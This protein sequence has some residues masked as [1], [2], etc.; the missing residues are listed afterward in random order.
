[1]E[2]VTADTARAVVDAVVAQASQM[3]VTSNVAVVDAGGNLKAFHRMDG[4]MLGS[5]D[6]AIK[7]A[8]TAR[9]F[10]MNT[11][12]LG[13]LTAPGGALAGIELT[14]DGLI[15]FGG[16]TPLRTTDGT[17]MGAV[18]VS[19]STV[20]DDTFLAATGAKAAS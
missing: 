18:G 1:M 4:A 8:R 6:V 3:G 13:P 12:E 10:D 15:T 14:N 11:E 16:G 17:V 9:L 19:G 20:D 2:D 5:A 7:K